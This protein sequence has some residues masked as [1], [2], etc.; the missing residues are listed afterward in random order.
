MHTP[1]RDDKVSHLDQWL[2]EE[3]Q[4]KARL[5]DAHARHGDLGYLTSD[6]LHTHAGVDI[7][8]AIARGDLLAPSIGKTLDFL[9]MSVEEGQAVFQGTP[10]PSVLNPMGGVHGGWYATLLDSAMAC[11]V[12][13]K[14]PKGRAYTTA[15]LSVNLVRGIGRTTRV[16]AIGR[17]LHCGRQMATAEGK[18]VG[19]D[20]TLYAHGTTTCLIFEAPPPQV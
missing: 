16:R 8:Q 5:A 4:Q 1:P 2:E 6:T 12:H 7:M 17:V 20:G 10:G 18:L 15:E 14:L 9:L 3:A 11:A 13:T 19:P